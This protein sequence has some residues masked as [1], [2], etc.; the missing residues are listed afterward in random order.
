MHLILSLEAQYVFY[1]CVLYYL[2]GFFNYDMFHCTS[3]IGGGGRREGGGVVI[4]D[5]NHEI[6]YCLYY[7]ELEEERKKLIETK[8]HLSLDLERLLNQSEV[9]V[10]L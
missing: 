8:N 9:I 7:R 3:T 4:I 2:E 10:K 1:K 6:P 5:E